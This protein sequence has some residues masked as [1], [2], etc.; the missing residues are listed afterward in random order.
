[1]FLIFGVQPAALSL[2]LPRV[3]FPNVAS[4]KT[5]FSTAN[6]RAL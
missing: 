4:V 1:V 5:V 6:Y 3:D 2:F